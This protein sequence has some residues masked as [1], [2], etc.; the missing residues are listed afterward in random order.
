MR[1][2]RERGGAKE[3]RRTPET[4][5][6]NS[7]ET[8]GGRKE[9]AGGRRACPKE[10]GVSL[11]TLPVES[12]QKEGGPPGYLFSRHLT[13]PSFPGEGFPKALGSSQQDGG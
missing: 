5:G 7:S 11:R 8:A 9:K 1:A 4:T 3:A 12:V 10:T 2:K 6:G 13:G